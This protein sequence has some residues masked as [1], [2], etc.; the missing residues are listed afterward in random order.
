MVVIFHLER[1]TPSNRDSTDRDDYVPAPCTH[2]PS[3]LPMDGPVKSSD[4][5]DMLSFR[6]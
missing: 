1:G 3:L 5:D 2:R 6:V 4:R